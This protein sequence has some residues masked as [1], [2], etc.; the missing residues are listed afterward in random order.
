VKAPATPQASNAGR[1]RAFFVGAMLV[2]IAG[3][4]VAVMTWSRR[5]SGGP[6]QAVTV[7]SAPASAPA[8]GTPGTA[9]PAAI[10]GA[11]TTRPLGDS[12]ART[13]IVLSRAESLAIAEAVRKRIT[14]R[15]D[16]QVAKGERAFADS[17]SRR[18]ER[19]L[20]DSLA[21]LMTELRGDGGSRFAASTRRSLERCRR[22]RSVR[23]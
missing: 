11:G 12:A 8:P 17:L 2:I 1:R 22:S 16:S 15:R 9:G 5:G 3:V 18:L 19:A 14:A 13:P 21:R 20:S 7:S 10:V 4:A 23:R 6:V